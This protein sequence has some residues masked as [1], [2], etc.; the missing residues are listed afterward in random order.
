M[1]SISAQSAFE[2]SSLEPLDDPV[3]SVKGCARQEPVQRIPK[4]FRLLYVHRAIA[5]GKGS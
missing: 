1:S 2:L 3:D 4:E 5:P